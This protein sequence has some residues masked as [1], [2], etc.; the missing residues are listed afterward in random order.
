MSLSLLQL[1]Y[2]KPLRKCLFFLNRWFGVMGGGTST[3]FLDKSSFNQVRVLGSRHRYL[4]EVHLFR[5]I[6][7]AVQCIGNTE[8]DP[9]LAISDFCNWSGCQRCWERIVVSLEFKGRK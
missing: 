5:F 7:S 4:L 1:D 9:G 2:R 6:S 8:N 3:L